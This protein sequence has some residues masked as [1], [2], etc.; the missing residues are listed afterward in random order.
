[1]A[2]YLIC[3]NCQYKNTVN[4]ERM[5]FCKGCN[6]KIA[7]NFLDWQKLKF[8]SSFAQYVE[9][10]DTYN[11]SLSKKTILEEPMAEK[12]SIFKSSLSSPSKKTV[13]FVAS[14]LIQLII[15][16]VL[17]GKNYYSENEQSDATITFLNHPSDYLKD[18]KWN[19]Y[20]ISQDLS[21]ILPFEVQ[22]SESILPCYMQNYIENSKSNKS[23]SSPSFSVSIEKM[24]FNSTCKIPDYDLI[25]TNDAYM[26]N[27]GVEILPDELLHTKIK[28]Y[29][30][31][32]E[33]GSYAMN[34]KD[35]LYENYTFI[36]GNEGVKVVLSYLKND[37][38]LC[39]YANVVTQSLLQKSKIS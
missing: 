16:F 32:V 38:I 25:A 30:T 20:S 33:H 2:N 17:L 26:K 3:D 1:M 31:H 11:A 29:T 28:G 21:L 6:K 18:V 8:N 12:K 14:V 10:L 35:Y 36:K 4:S 39:K 13:V 24:E 23:E 19:H 7:N 34:G 5:V 27:P 37:H 9:E 15:T 22:E